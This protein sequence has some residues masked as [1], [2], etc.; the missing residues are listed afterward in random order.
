MKISF[1]LFE[2]TFFEF[3][4]F[5]ALWFI[6]AIFTQFQGLRFAQFS[7]SFLKQ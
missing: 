7:S 4:H 6:A 1:S 3:L 2:L 5:L